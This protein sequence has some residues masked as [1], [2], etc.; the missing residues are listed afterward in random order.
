LFKKSVCAIAVG[1]PL[2]REQ[3]KKKKKDEVD[4]LLDLL[5]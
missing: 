5:F 4:N 2:K 1:H 3:Q